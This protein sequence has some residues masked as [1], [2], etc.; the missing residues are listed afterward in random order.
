MATQ[1]DCEFIIITSAAYY[2][3]WLWVW[4]RVFN[5]NILYLM[6]YEDKI[7]LM[8]GRR[9]HTIP[10]FYLKDFLKPGFVYRKGTK[11][12]RSVKT[13]N[14]VAV[15]VNFYGAPSDDLEVLDKMN[16]KIEGWAAP[17]IRKL[18][19]DVTTITY[20]D[21]VI[22]SY[23]IANMYIRTPAFH[24]SMTKLFQTHT[25]KLNKMAEYMKKA[26]EKAQSKGED[27]SVFNS[28]NL[29]DAPKT[30]LDEWNKWMEVEVE[31]IKD[32]A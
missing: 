15:N 3:A 19:D 24:H 17:V 10:R 31:D 21:W 25:Q 20:D 8:S 9:Q 4:E 28:P 2:A 16:T 5:N 11:L 12:P 6:L 32:S 23:Y 14:N 30:S 26:Y 27:L 13:P 1:V 7:C 18:V 29:D 22:L